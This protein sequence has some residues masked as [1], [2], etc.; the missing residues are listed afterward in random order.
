MSERRTQAIIYAPNQ[1]LYDATGLLEARLH[2]NGV[3]LYPLY[4]VN[5]P[6][7]LTTPEESVV[8]IAVGESALDAVRDAMGESQ[9]TFGRSRRVCLIAPDWSPVF[10]FRPTLI[11]KPTLA[12]KLTEAINQGRLDVL[13]FDTEGKQIVGV[14]A[15]E[16]MGK[17]IPVDESLIENVLGL[18]KVIEE[19]VVFAKSAVESSLK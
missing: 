3:P 14:A 17:Q 1:Q 11:P 19:V 10:P 2:Q 18:D 4:E 9:T 15:L 12:S 5:F 16:Q 13:S 8:L 6:Q 7:V